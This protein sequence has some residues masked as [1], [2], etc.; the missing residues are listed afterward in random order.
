MNARSA[1]SWY[2]SLK[3]AIEDRGG[4]HNAHLHLDRAGTF[5]ERYWGESPETPLGSSRVSLAQKHNLIHRIHASR[6]YDQTDFVQRVDGVLDVMAQA[7]T[8]VAESL[9]DVTADNVG[10]DALDLMNE[11]KQK[12]SDIELRV[13]AYS[14]FG[15]RDDDP[16]RWDVFEAGARRADFIGCLPEADDPVEH[17]GHIGFVEHLKRVLYLARDLS[18]PI[19]VHV[20]QRFEESETGTEDLITVVREIGWIPAPGEDPMIWAVHVVSPSTYDDRRFERMVSGLVECGIGIVTCPSAALGMRMYRPLLTPTGNA[21]PR[22][23]EMLAAGVR[24]RIGSDNIDDIC[25]PSTTADL[26]DEVFALSA[27]LRF[28]DVQVL[29]AIA[30]G[31]DLTPTDRLRVQQHVKENLIA[32]DRFVRS[33]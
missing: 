14:P 19:Q 9:V 3:V 7:G 24:V 33:R 25:S 6:A 22:I 8:T 11:V 5:D 10:L 28:Y 1:S 13:G 4:M 23:L 30:S 2:R 26:V 21:I 17:P 27:A 29:A 31:V 15:F 12:R 16:Q 18:I 20:D 32:I